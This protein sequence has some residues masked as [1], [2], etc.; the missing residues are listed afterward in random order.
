MSSTAG[1]AAR[2]REL[3][4]PTEAMAQEAAPTA[5]WTMCRQL[6]VSHTDSRQSFVHA[7]QGTGTPAGTPA[8][9]T[10]NGKDCG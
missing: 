7:F 2:D 10:L 1:P 3:P 9:F 4:A 5:S 6:S 8:A